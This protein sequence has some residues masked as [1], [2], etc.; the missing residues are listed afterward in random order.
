MLLCWRVEYENGSR[1][2]IIEK[3]RLSEGQKNGLFRRNVPP[4]K[5]VNEIRKPQK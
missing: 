1:R 5:K 2:N 3:Q 4:P